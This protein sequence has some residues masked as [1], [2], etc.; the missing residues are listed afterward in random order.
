MQYIGTSTNILEQPIARAL[1]SIGL[2]HY[3]N[4]QG[5]DALSALTRSLEIHRQ[6][7]NIKGIATLTS[8]VGIVDFG[9]GNYAD[10]L[11]HYTTSLAIQ[12]NLVYETT[13]DY[14]TALLLYRCR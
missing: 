1:S 7:D 12:V 5:P 2:V 9:M 14:P 3:I 8:F 10:A 13:G 6:H 11:E 4:G